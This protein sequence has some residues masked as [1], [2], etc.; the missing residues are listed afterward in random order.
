[1]LDA[2]YLFKTSY[3]RSAATN[4]MEKMLRD[5]DSSLSNI[6]HPFAKAACNKELLKFSIPTSIPS[7][8]THSTQ[9]PDLSNQRKA[10]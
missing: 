5:I 3:A 4:A 9:S 1:M 10:Q 2:C 6:D 7:D 8:T